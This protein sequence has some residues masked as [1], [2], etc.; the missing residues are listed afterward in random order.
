[1]VERPVTS[2]ELPDYERPPVVEIVI[3]VQFV[4]LPQFGMREAV[5][6][7]RAFEGWEVIDVVPA[8]EPIVE[9][10][11]GHLVAPTLRF[12]L[13]NPPV[14]VVLGHEGEHWLAQ[15]QQDRLVA[16]ERKVEQ[17]PSFANVVPKLREVVE[18]AAQALDRPLLAE[19]H[20][21]ELIEVIY[22]NRIP[23]GEGWSSFAELHKVLRTFAA[24]AGAG[25]FANFEQAQV[26]FA[27]ELAAGDRFDG[28]LRVTAEPQVDPDQTR[29]LQL[30]LI[31]RR[32]VHT[33]RDLES[34]LDRCHVDIVEGFTAVTTER[35]HEIWGRRR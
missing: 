1:M 33:G 11:A 17:R 2:M 29:F 15:V 12:G 22:G 27:Y 8:L 28:R 20:V 4:P 32:F 24:E 13:G 26:G 10:P 31:S 6:V 18:H 14:R 7:S 9:A 30:Q 5:A 19:P 34:V 3:G 21:P 23:V 35:M 25:R 16:H